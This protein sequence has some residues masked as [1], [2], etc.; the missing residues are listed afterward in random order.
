MAKFMLI[1][2]ETPGRFRQLSP[3]EMQRTVQ[4]Y[5][6]WSDKIRAAGRMVASDKLTEDGG[7]VLTASEGRLRV[8]DGPYSEAKE[9]V[10]GFF[11]F[12]ADNDEQAIEMTRDCPHLNFGRIELRKVDAMGCGQE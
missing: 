5:K 7:K 4:K 8:V 2:H 6:S 3:E 1:L 12:R 10:G 9:I 11:V